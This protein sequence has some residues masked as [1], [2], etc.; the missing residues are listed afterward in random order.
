MICFSFSKLQL[1]YQLVNSGPKRRG[2]NS[3]CTVQF[4]FMWPVNINYSICFK[5]FPFALIH[6]TMNL[7]NRFV[8][9][10]SYIS[11]VSTHFYLWL[12]RHQI[13]FNVSE[14]PYVHPTLCHLKILHSFKMWTIGLT[15]QSLTPW[16]S[17]ISELRTRRNTRE[18]KNRGWEI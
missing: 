3:H 14:L 2:K 16:K 6:E 13:S 18:Y 4:C 5:P 8:L 11:K 1:N 10:H 7:C 15:D 9:D 12:F 17:R